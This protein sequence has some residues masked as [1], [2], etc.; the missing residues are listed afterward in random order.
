MPSRKKAMGKAK[1]AAKE[2]AAAATQAK[3]GTNN[4]HQS[5]PRPTLTSRGVDDVL[6]GIESM[7]LCTTHGFRL[8]LLPTMRICGVFIDAFTE[9]YR[10]SLQM[11][12]NVITALNAASAVCNKPMFGPVWTDVAKMEYV[13]AYYVTKGVKYILD[14]GRDDMAHNFAVFA[15]YFEQTIGVANKT[16]PEVIPAKLAELL[17]GDMNTLVKYFR[18]HIPCN[19]LDEK[20][21]EV[22]SITKLGFCCYSECP[23]PNRTVERKKM[24]YCTQC[25]ETNYCSRECQVAHWPEHKDGCLKYMEKKANLP[26]SPVRK[27]SSPKAQ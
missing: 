10:I 2:E 17:N 23:I 4:D 24:L 5:P 18:Q 1:K 25:R 20:Y 3:A 26:K 14:E 13:K 22:K 21:K 6:R 7:K 11:E 16:Q 15:N 19:C 8:E 27:S 12:S 9:A